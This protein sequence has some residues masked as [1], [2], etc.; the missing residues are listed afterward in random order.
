MPEREGLMPKTQAGFAFDENAGLDANKAAF[1]A[2]MD[3]LDSILAAELR[4]ETF[5]SGTQDHS[6]SRLS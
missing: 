2:H 1:A 6:A 3:E 4:I 5:L